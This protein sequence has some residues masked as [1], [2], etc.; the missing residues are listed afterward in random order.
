M[1]FLFPFRNERGLSFEQN[2]IPCFVPSLVKIG[3]VVL[4][5]KTKK[6]KVYYNDDNDDDNNNKNNDD[7]EQQI[8]IRKAHLTFPLR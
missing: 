4:E 1:Y 2:W 7:D 8:S 5:K 6:W 3:L